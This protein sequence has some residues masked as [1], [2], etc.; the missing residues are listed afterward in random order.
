MSTTYLTTEELAARIGYSPR[1]VRNQLVGKYL[2]EGRHFV[3]PFGRK[4]LFIWEQVEKDM[5]RPQSVDD[6]MAGIQ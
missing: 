2:F 6:L 5:R 4:L 1:T 3:R